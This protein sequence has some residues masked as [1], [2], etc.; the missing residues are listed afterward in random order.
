[1]YGYTAFLCRIPGCSPMLSIYL[2]QSS[3]VRLNDTIKHK[4]NNYILLYFCI[5]FLG[6]NRVLFVISRVKCYFSI[7]LFSL[8]ITFVL[9]IVISAYI[10]TLIFNCI[11]LYIC[12]LQCFLMCYR[13]FLYTI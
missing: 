12:L 5:R 13:G 2:S 4:S 3:S 6:S 1:M 7:G 10:V 9:V 8:R 11:I